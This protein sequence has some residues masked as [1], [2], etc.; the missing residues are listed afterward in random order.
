MLQPIKSTWSSKGVSIV[1][2]G[3]SDPDG[4]SGPM[5]LRAINTAGDTKSK[6]YIFERLVETIDFIGAENVV[7]V[8]TDNASNCI[9]L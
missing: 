6:E 7:Q 3:W 9:K 1:S 5:F 4:L 2:D 8:V